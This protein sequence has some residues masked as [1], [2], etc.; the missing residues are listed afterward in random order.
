MF[1][2]EREDIRVLLQL[3]TVISKRYMSKCLRRGGN[4]SYVLSVI[5]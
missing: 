5:L 4:F 2:N 3:C 1:I